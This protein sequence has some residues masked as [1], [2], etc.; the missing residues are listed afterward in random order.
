MLGSKISAIGGGIVEASKDALKT[1]RSTNKGYNTAQPVRSIYLPMP[2]NLT[3]NEQVDWQ[4]TD[5]GAM[6]L[7]RDKIMSGQGSASE[8][9]KY[10]GLSQ[11]GNLAGG[12]A[13]GLV[14]TLFG[15]GILGGAAGAMLGGGSIQGA[16]ESTF[17]VKT[18][19][20]KEQ[21]FGGVPFRPFEF[22]WT[23]T[24]RNDAELGAIGDIIKAIR[25]HSKPSFQNPESRTIFNYP[26]EFQINFKTLHTD[27]ET[28][29]DNN[30]LPRLKPM[31]C[32]SVN[33]NYTTAGW[34]SF[35]NG[36]PTS[37]TL[38]LGFEEIDIITSDEVNTFGGF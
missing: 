3:Y 22:S 21:T 26:D 36:A 14:G 11:L 24:A 28:L 15:G 20:F 4:G 10:A 17:R 5:L 38:Q 35:E 19:P 18:N 13:G 23:L 7:A 32:K 25:T 9:A 8:S 16:V 30:Y 6:A 33:T 34:R 27:N 2:E 12:A 29:L 1:F 31:V 37:V